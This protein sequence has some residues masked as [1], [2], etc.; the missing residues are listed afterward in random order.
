M[1]GA[2]A[3]RPLARSNPTGVLE[4]RRATLA[5][6]YGDIWM[7]TI[8]P[9]GLAPTIPPPPKHRAKRAVMLALVGVLLLAIALVWRLLSQPDTANLFVYDNDAQ[10]GGVFRRLLYGLSAGATFASV[11][12]SVNSLK[13]ARLMSVVALTLATAWLGAIVWL[14]LA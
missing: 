14:L 10:V 6:C 13:H 8:P 4:A 12:Y 3:E 7:A 2:D 11:A 9:A 1:G 5:S